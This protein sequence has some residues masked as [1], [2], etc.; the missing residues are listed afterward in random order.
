MYEMRDDMEKRVEVDIKLVAFIVEEC[1]VEALD[2]DWHRVDCNIP[3]ISNM[4]Y[5]QIAIQPKLSSEMFRAD[6]VPK[7]MTIPTVTMRIVRDY[8]NRRLCAIGE[9]EG[10]GTL[11]FT[12]W[13]RGYW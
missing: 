1:G 7:R 10:E 12:D 5:F 2:L 8:A 3:D 9:R 11:Y 13:I 6:Y 4:A